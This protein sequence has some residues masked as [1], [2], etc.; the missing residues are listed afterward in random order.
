MADRIRT[1]PAFRL[2]GL[3][4]I[5]VKGKSAALNV[6]AV[7]RAAATVEAPSLETPA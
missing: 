1:N 3:E 2:E 7:E 5:K 4:P 6:Y